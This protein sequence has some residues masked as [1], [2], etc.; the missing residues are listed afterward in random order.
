MHRQ[1]LMKSFILGLVVLLAVLP[2]LGVGTYYLHLIIMTFVFTLVV[3]GMRFIALVGEMSFGQPAFM[4]VGAY[5]S[6]LLMVKAGLAFSVS[7]VLAI[8]VGLVLAIAVG[9]VSLTTKGVYFFLVT[10][11]FSEIVRQTLLNIGWVGGSVGLM[12]IMSTFSIANRVIVNFSS[13]PSSYYFIFVVLLVATS[14]MYALEKS[15]VGR[16]FNAIR[17]QDSVAESIG[18]NVRRY[19]LVAFVIGSLCAV[20]GGIF[21]APY[22]HFI[23]PDTFGFAT[24]LSILVGLV[25]GGTGT[26]AG[27]VL[28]SL[29]VI[30]VPEIVDITK[31]I[32]IFLW[33]ICIVSVVMAMPEGI[34]GWLVAIKPRVKRL[35]AR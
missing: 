20:L 17:Q 34:S 32:Q 6:V 24:G 3:M 33:G 21:F 25:I 14:I 8:M 1:I 16:T 29:F 2:L 4:A 30:F 28:G 23:N 7:S 15:W 10:F 9:Y 11:A 13:K 5:A 27:P 26:V 31:D 18:V 12:G 35:I 19:K 22:I